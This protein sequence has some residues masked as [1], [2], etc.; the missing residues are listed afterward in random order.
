MISSTL[1]NDREEFVAIFNTAER[2][3]VYSNASAL[4]ID[5]L[6]ILMQPPRQI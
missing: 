5:I 3:I 6:K 2:L 1:F 4:F